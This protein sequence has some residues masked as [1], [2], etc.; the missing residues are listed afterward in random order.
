MP[1]FCSRWV[2]QFVGWMALTRIIRG[3][4]CR[5]ISSTYSITTRLLQPY[6]APPGPMFGLSVVPR[7]MPAVDPV[8]MIDAPSGR[9]G[10]ATATVFI[11]PSRSTSLASTNP[12]GSGLTHR[13]RQDAG[14]GD[15]DVDLA[16]VGHARLDRVAQFV[17][18]AHVG[19]PCHDP[20]ARLLDRTL[21]LGEVVGRRQRIRVGR[22][23][24]TDVDGDDVGALPGHRDRVRAALAARRAGDESD[25]AVEFSGH[26]CS[27][28]IRRSAAGVKVMCSSLRP[29]MMKVGS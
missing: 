1:S 29:R 16:E 13:H 12:I 8:T 2:L 14:V 10:I 27:L 7:I 11:T 15:D 24:A 28:S 4:R 26:V 20:A 23:V 5:H 22:D 17:A 3:A 25:L 9:C 19:D 21:G 18:L 6:P